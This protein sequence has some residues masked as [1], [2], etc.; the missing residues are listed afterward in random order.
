ML[1]LKV[2]ADLF[3]PRTLTILGVWFL[4]IF[5]VIYPLLPNPSFEVRIV[6]IVQ[7]GSG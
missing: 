6:E 4:L 1:K 5:F 2:F 3:H 7:N